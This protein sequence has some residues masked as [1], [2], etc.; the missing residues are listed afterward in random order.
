MKKIIVIIVLFL[1]ISCFSVPVCSY[2]QTPTTVYTLQDIV[3]DASG[4]NFDGG[5]PYQMSV[6]L[7]TSA[8]QYV[9]GPTWNGTD[10]VT[11][12]YSSN[13]FPGGTY[14]TKVLIETNEGAAS[15]T[16]IKFASIKVLSTYKHQT[17]RFYSRR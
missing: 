9:L 17:Q 11:G 14:G 2:T 8:Y 13:G 15:D 7:N 16:D 12:N 5:T 10:T 3:F 4:S 6:S 1:A